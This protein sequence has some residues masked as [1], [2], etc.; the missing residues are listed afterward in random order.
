MGGVMGKK[1]ARNKRNRCIGHCCKEQCFTFDYEQYEE[2]FTNELSKVL[3]K[4]KL[5]YLSP[6][7]MEFLG[8]LKILKH[9]EATHSS[10]GYHAYLH[11]F[12]LR[13]YHQTGS[14]CSK[15]ADMN[16]P[17][18]SEDD[19]TYDNKYGYNKDIRKL[20]IV[21]LG[22]GGVGKSALTIRIV[23][24]NSL[25][26]YEP[27]IEDSYRKQI[28]VDGEE[29][30]V[31]IMDTAGC[32]EFIRMDD[33][34]YRMVIH[35]MYDGHVFLICFAINN[36]SS[37]DE[38]IIMRQKIIRAKDSDYAPMIL[39]ATKCDLLYNDFDH[40]KDHFVDREMVMSYAEECRIPYI[41]T[42]AKLRKN[43]GFL[44]KYCLYEERIKL[45]MRQHS[46]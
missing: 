11:P 9:F 42:S 3:K 6:I 5:E 44:I 27:T 17:P 38:A 31:D 15:N 46:L 43:V 34:S 16:V 39:V 26:E 30:L 36:K 40:N 14:P 35:R 33:H 4:N 37:F 20:K 24:D 29:I 12:T 32:Q 8:N 21:V 18:L 10:E 7:I 19:L 2:R 1:K 41:E 45:E 23:T 13:V 25:D 28:K 22:T